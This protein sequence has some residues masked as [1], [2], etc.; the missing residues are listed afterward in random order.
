M[1]NGL[2]MNGLNGHYDMRLGSHT[3]TSAKY[4]AGGGA[5]VAT[6]SDYGK[7]QFKG[8]EKKTKGKKGSATG[9]MGRFPDENIITKENLVRDSYDRGFNDINGARG[10]QERSDGSRS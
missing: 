2:Q 6:Q 9:G 3:I 4:A 1:N 7:R 8:I 5:I 10:V